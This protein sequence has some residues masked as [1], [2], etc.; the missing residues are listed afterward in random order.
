MKETL[1]ATDL[2]LALFS[3][4]YFE[5][6]RFTTGEWSAAMLPDRRLV[7]VRI[8]DCRVPRLF[9][10]LIAPTLFDVPEP[11]ARRRLLAA[12]GRPTR[13]TDRPAWPGSPPRSPGTLPGIWNVPGRNTHFTGR[14]SLLHRMNTHLTGGEAPFSIALHG[15]GGVGKTQL[16]TEYAYR[17]AADYD[18]AWWLASERTELLN[19]QLALLATTI[20]LAP[21]GADAAV[22]ARAVLTDLRTRSR[23][24]LVFDNAEDPEALRPWLPGGMGHILITSRNPGWHE[25]AVVTEV[26]VFTRAESVVLFRTRGLGSL[27]DGEVDLLADSLG[28]LPLALV[29]A[30]GV[31][32]ETGMAARDFLDLLD[33]EAGEI[34]DEGKP[35]SYPVSLG[36]AIRLAADRL[37]DEE[38]VAGEL[39]RLCAFL[40]AE[41]IP[42]ALLRRAWDSVHSPPGTPAGANASLRRA[43]RLA[44]RYGLVRADRTGLQMHRLTQVVLCE[45]YSAGEQRSMLDRA[46]SIVVLA[47]PGDSADPATWPSWALLLPH[48]LAVEPASVTDQAG[49]CDLACDATW[50]LH[51]RGDHEAGLQLARRLFES[52]QESLGPDDANTFRAA[53]SLVQAY[54]DLGFLSDARK[55]DEHI[56]ERRREVIGDYHLDTLASA[57]NVAMNSRAGGEPA[58]ARKLDESTMEARA[59]ILGEDHEDTL[60]SA[61]NLAIDLVVLGDYDAGRRLDER[62]LARRRALLGEDHPCTLTSAN[63]LGV[64]YR[65]LGQVTKARSLHRKIYG[66]RREIL[67]DGHP[68]TLTSA[69]NVGV[70]ARNDEDPEEARRFHSDTLARRRRLFGGEHHDTLTSAHNLAAAL[71]HC[72]EPATARKLNEGTYALRRE[73]FG[74]DHPDTLTSAANLAVSL[75]AT[76]DVAA[77]RRL[78]EDTYAHRRAAFGDD[79][80]DTLMVAA[81]LAHNLFLLHDEASAIQL[82]KDT[83]NRRC[84]VLGDRH[85]DTL[86]SAG[87]LAHYHRVVARGG[88]TDS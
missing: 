48:L 40:A 39:L 46:R 77:A 14:S 19:E 52:W 54:R 24:L 42:L 11:E 62:T 84:R 8:A 53:D 65:L 57:H 69:N 38:P 31:L 4:E 34:L 50:Y 82:A 22:G 47:H 7:P 66:R 71:H 76:G 58:L 6:D 29:Q 86:V 49:M 2:V 9:A 44:V 73:A 3:P 81:N 68:H 80:P 79:H 75:C 78:N 87:N 18:L 23:W 64:T 43:S 74:P 83:L 26:D 59:R 88:P 20:G 1:D 15:M 32:A 5:T 13:P 30:A 61:N 72:N 41:P 60:A 27:D 37:T 56:L 12:V 10:A 33:A 55:L 85:P 63:N 36:A 70:S 25:L 45:G 67:G 28:D 21:T 16:A 17:Y 51:A 35:I